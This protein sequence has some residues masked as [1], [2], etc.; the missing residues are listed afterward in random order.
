MDYN[1]LKQ[2][3][4]NP[5]TFNEIKIYKIFCLTLKPLQLKVFTEIPKGFENAV[6]CK[7][8]QNKTG[9]ETKNI[10]STINQLMNK[11][12][13]YSTGLNGKLKYYRD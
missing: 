3:I 4:N 8:I 6:S 2:I 1:Q 13:I 11:Y 5:V 12:P 9:I 10:S 7:D